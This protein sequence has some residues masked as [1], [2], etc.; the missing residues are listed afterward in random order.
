[1]TVEKYFKF[2]NNSNSWS[3]F[4]LTNYMVYIHSWHTFR[5]ES[6]RKHL[7][8]LNQK[9]W[10]TD[11]FL[12]FCIATEI[13][14]HQLTLALCGFVFKDSLN[15]FDSRPDSARAKIAMWQKPERPIWIWISS[16]LH[17]DSFNGFLAS[18]ISQL[19]LTLSSRGFVFPGR[20]DTGQIARLRGPK[21][22]IL[23][24]GFYG[25][26]GVQRL[27]WISWPLLAPF[28]RCFWSINEIVWYNA[29]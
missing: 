20:N 3:I 24:L 21:M 8:P 17:E 7:A 16:S 23:N 27:L 13:S 22:T 15:T 14:Q 1:M 2:R 29:W 9:N 18:W 28:T 12:L 26:A 5:Q 11:F 6:T 25:A 19:S 10:C 4:R